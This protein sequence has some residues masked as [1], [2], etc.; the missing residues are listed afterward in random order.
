MNKFNEETR[1]I[2]TNKKQTDGTFFF[3]VAAGDRLIYAEKF[4][5]GAK[6]M[7]KIMSEEV[8]STNGKKKCP[9]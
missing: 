3:T 7:Y 6:N 2:E 8:S 1:Q 9:I 4:R 5:F